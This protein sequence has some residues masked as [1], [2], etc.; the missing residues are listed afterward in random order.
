MKLP[1]GEFDA[2]LQLN[3]RPQVSYE[4]VGTSYIPLHIAP[5]NKTLKQAEDDNDST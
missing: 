3:S 1:K 5:A 2:D 4:S